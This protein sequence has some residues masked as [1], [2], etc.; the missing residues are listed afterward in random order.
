[1]KMLGSVKKPVPVAQIVNLNVL[2]FTII[3][4]KCCRLSEDF[5]HR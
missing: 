2:N 4:K 1:M 5:G 3:L